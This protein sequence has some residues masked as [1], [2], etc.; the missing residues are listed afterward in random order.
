MSDHFLEEAC[1]KL[2]SRWRSVGRIVGVR[3]M[4]GFPVECLKKGVM[5]VLKLQVRV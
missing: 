2:M 4:D 1:L 5:A 3:N